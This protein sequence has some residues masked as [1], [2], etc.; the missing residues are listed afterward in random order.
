VVEVVVD[1]A[2]VP[3]DVVDA[4]EVLTLFLSSSQAVNEA[5][6]SRATARP[7]SGVRRM[8]RP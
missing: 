7:R 2:S 3:E 8:S 1:V 5:E 6:K 4:E